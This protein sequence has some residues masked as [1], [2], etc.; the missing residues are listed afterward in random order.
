M[1]TD[2]FK[3]VSVEMTIKLK[4]FWLRKKRTKYHVLQFIYEILQK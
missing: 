3:I 2:L 4:C 1:K